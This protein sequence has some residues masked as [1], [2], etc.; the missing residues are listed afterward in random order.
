MGRRRAARD[1]TNEEFDEW[2]RATERMESIAKAADEPGGPRLSLVPAPEQNIA[3]PTDLLP[4]AGNGQDGAPP[5][6][7]K[8]FDGVPLEDSRKRLMGWSAERQRIF[9]SYLA[10]TGSVHLASDAA[11]LSA[12]SAY[13]LRV[14]SPA[15]AAAWDLAERLAVG[16]L[17]ALAFDRAINGR[18]EQVWHEGTLVAEKRTPSDRLLMWLLARLD[19]KR[20][21]AP[22]EQRTDIDVDPQAEARASFAGHLDALT[23]A[24]STG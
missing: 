16:R 21:G 10:E 13:R 18:M 2:A 19:P 3:W 12:R 4:P 22:W 1:M 23:D 6:A 17:S 9:L 5:V 20:Y 11:R 24:V 15:F 8:P 7:A 14:R